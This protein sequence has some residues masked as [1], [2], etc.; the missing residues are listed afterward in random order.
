MAPCG[1]EARGYRHQAV[2]V[3]ARV[4]GV[5]AVDGFAETAAVHEHG[6]AGLEV[7]VL[8]ADDD[9]GE[10]DAAVQRMPAQYLAGA[11]RGQR[12]L[13]VDRGVADLDDDVAFRQVVD[14]H[15]LETGN[16]LA[17]L[18]VDA[19]CAKL[20]HRISPLL[21]LEPAEPGVETL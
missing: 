1:V 2:A 13:V 16:D 15:V 11:G 7:G 20:V 19:V 10:V 18:F 12:V 17:V 9:A 3:E 5:A 4:L 21:S 8:R 14:R 6:G